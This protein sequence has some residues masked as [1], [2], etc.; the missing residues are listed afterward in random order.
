MPTANDAKRTTKILVGY[1]GSDCAV[2]AIK[3]LARA[4]LPATGTAIVLAVASSSQVPAVAYSPAS[5]A[6]SEVSW[7]APSTWQELVDE[8]TKETMDTASAGEAL[9]RSIL[10]N[11][12]I[13]GDHSLDSA[14]RG[15]VDQAEKHAVSLIV[16]GSHGRSTLGRMLLGSTSQFVLGHAQ[17]S[18]RVGRRSSTAP[19]SPLRIV[20]GVDG[21]AGSFAAIHEVTRRHWPEGT[22]FRVLASV[23]LRLSAALAGHAAAAWADS[24]YLRHDP[25]AATPTQI[26]QAASELLREAGLSAVQVVEEGD[27]KATLVEH[28]QRWGADAIF[29][30]A[31]GLSRTQRFFLGSVSSAVAARAH[32]SVEVVRSLEGMA[33]VVRSVE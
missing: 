3:D 19:G 32:C 4:G 11:W 13:Q 5:A 18:V 6:L 10:P 7:V 26:V 25:Q 29:L 27:P 17:C 22:A 20:V 1:D 2:D 24:R 31:T 16:V 15:I 14:Y 30:G 12:E 23:D 9:V 21:S 8:A 33:N 28:A